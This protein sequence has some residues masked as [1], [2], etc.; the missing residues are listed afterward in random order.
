MPLSLRDTL[1]WAAVACCAVA[2]L[3]ILRSVVVPSRASSGGDEA[4][5]PPVRRRAIEIAYA[6]IPAV[7]LGLVL[8]GTWPR[9]RAL[10]SAR[11][12]GA[13]TS[14]PAAS[15]TPAAPSAPSPRAHTP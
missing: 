6:L 8:A 10:H 3:A 4:S 14:P 13:D 7:A 2:S 5:A 9:V 12:E 11:A 1:F 15:A